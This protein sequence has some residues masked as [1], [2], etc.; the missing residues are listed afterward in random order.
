MTHRPELLGYLEIGRGVIGIDL[1]DA[2]E[3]LVGPVIFKPQS[4]GRGEQAE[5]FEVVRLPGQHALDRVRR[6]SG[7]ALLKQ[8]PRFEQIG[9]RRIAIDLA[10]GG[11][12]G[13]GGVEVP[14]L[15]RD[16]AEQ[17]V[18]MHVVGIR[19]QGSLQLGQ[20]LFGI[21]VREKVLR[22]RHVGRPIAAVDYVVGA[23]KEIEQRIVQLGKLLVR[24]AQR[25]P[26]IDRPTDQGHLLGVV[27]AFFLILLPLF[28]VIVRIG[29]E[30]LVGGSG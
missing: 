20:G 18:G 3:K 30:P 27:E 24:A 1:L 16:L 26:P 15:H 7:T 19:A 11:N 12:L 17:I 8:V 23:D 25:R 29:D 2:F 9:H 14:L 21:V 28:Q 22:P 13:I 4:V 5:R 10:D 6:I